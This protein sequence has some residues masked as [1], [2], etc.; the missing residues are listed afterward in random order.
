MGTGFRMAEESA[1]LVGGFGR[2][3]MLELACLLLDLGFVFEREA[4]GEKPLS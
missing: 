4:I 3:Y 1:D 2:Q